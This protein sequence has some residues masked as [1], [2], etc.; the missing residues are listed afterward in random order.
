MQIIVSLPFPPSLNRLWRAGKGKVYRSAD[1]EAWRSE[2]AWEAR[3]QAGTRKIAGQF[4]II[5]NVVR[6][7]RRHRDIDN[8]LKA[9]LDCLQHAGVIKNDKNCEHIEIKWVEDGPPCEVILEEL[10]N[11]EEK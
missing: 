11:G 9:V 8:L 5:V 7:D 3:R 2:S 4:R 10:T 6:P 1:Y